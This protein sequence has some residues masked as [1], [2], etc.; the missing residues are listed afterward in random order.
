LQY[1]HSSLTVY[2]LC[3]LPHLAGSA[4]FVHLRLDTSARH[5]RRCWRCA[6]A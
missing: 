3:L 1:A 5:R 6:N 4:L 2:S